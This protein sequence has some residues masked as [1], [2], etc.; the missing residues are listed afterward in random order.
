MT[1]RSVQT[2]LFVT[3]RRRSKH[4]RISAP[5]PPA[6]FPLVDRA[7]IG[8]PVTMP[9]VVKRWIVARCAST[10]TVMLGC[11]SCRQPL[12]NITQLLY[13]LEDAPGQTHVLARE[14][15]EHGWET[16]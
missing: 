3:T 9:D 10:S 5:R 13:H 8:E 6:F 1:R 11:L 4:T 14:C 15:G 2:D 16:L 7:V 12:A